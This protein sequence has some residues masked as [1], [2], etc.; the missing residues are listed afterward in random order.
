M[1]MIDVLARTRDLAWWLVP[2]ATLVVIL[3]VEVGA[4]G[5]AAPV[6]VAA[7]PAPAT[8]SVPALLPEYGIPGG[9]D[10]R[11]ETVNRTLFNPTRRPAPTP[12]PETAK[13]S[14]PRGQFA[15]TGTT[16]VDGKGTAFLR[17]V[18]GGKFRRVQQGDTINGMLVAEVKPDR[19]KLTMGDDSEDLVLK[20]IGN[21]KPTP[22]TAPP[23]PPTAVASAPAA[24]APQTPEQAAQT[25]LERRRAARAAAAAAQQQNAGTAASIPR[26][27]GLN[28][29]ARRGEGAMQAQRAAQAAETA[30]A[31]ANG[32][33]AAGGT[34][35]D[36]FKQYQQRAAPGGQ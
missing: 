26:A 17:E 13:P 22:G 32:N 3:G 10:N 36:V 12:A 16:V 29:A 5:M 2:F 21:S 1:T 35:G 6:V 20:V 30:A 8:A 4:R 15:L 23:A 28:G 7:N 24:G 19:V 11:S 34:W 33:A 25:L 9:V 18:N 31:A 27:P 14:M